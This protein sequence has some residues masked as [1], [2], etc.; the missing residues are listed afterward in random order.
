MRW[1]PWRRRRARW[2]C[3]WSCRV[4]AQRGAC[5]NDLGGGVPAANADGDLV[6]GDGAGGAAGRDG[7]VVG[8]AALQQRIQGALGWLDAEAGFDRAQQRW[9]VVGGGPGQELGEG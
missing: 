9:D 5:A 7:R 6:L 2:W 8:P 4:P 3:W 1:A